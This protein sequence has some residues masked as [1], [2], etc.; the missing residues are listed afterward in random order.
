[1]REA[2]VERASVLICVFDREEAL[3]ALLK[4]GGFEVLSKLK[5]S[6]QKKAFDESVSGDFFAQ[7]EKQLREYDSRYSLDHIVVASPA[8]WRDPF[9]KSLSDP[10]IKR[11]LTYATCSSVSES[12]INEVL[13]REELSSA[14]KK[15]RIAREVDFVE[16]LMAGIAK[17]SAVCY[18]FADVENA[19]AAGAVDFLLVSDSLI[20]RL[21][22][23]NDF[24]RLD[25]L[26][27][28]VDSQ[29]GSVVLV[30][31]AHD[32][33]RKLDGIGG[34]GALLRYKLSY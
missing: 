27:R 17:D 22:E 2:E 29:R 26:M 12:A 7:I 11:K 6:V 16:R 30:S 21:R 18:G 28:S 1:M 31:S 32:A 25:Q 33:G 23:E 15:D 13:K 5:G 24:F 10:D 34:I 20:K 4:R 19:A 8:F 3:F 9:L 14:L